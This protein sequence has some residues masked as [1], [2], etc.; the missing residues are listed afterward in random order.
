MKISNLEIN[1]EPNVSQDKVEKIS[2]LLK[3]IE[4]S[5]VALIGPAVKNSW[6]CRFIKSELE[7]SE[8]N[9]R[10][11]FLS[12]DENMRE[13]EM[14]HELIHAWYNLDIKYDIIEEGLVM[15]ITNLVCLKNKIADALDFDYEISNNFL[16]LVSFA[17]VSKL[18]NF[19]PLNMYR[20]RLVRD[21]WLKGEQKKPGFLKRTCLLLKPRQDNLY[22]PDYLKIIDEDYPIS[23]ELYLS[24]FKY[25]EASLK[26][27]LARNEGPKQVAAVINYSHKDIRVI[28]SEK[29]IALC[30]DGVKKIPILSDQPWDIDLNAQFISKDKSFENTYQVKA[31]DGMVVFTTD[32]MPLNQ[33]YILNVSTTKFKLKD[34][35]IFKL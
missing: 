28:C 20:Y 23:F 6:T 30:Y 5:I 29:K 11:F 12:L 33:D 8:M 17:P 9:A 32:R 16:Q 2:G 19:M 25:Y 24:I 7:Y 15:A 13:S 27:A 35:L 31:V 4:N 34:Q 3:R 21:I 18:D 26:K 1:F 22:L 14:I 10:K